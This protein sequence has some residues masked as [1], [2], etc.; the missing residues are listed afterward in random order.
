MEKGVLLGT[1]DGVG[2]GVSQVRLRFVAG[3]GK[4]VW[5][6]PQSLLGALQ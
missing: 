4:L 1:Q 6:A 3:E 5:E 2:K